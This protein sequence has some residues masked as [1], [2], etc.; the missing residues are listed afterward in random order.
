MKRPVDLFSHSRPRKKQTGS[1]PRP[2]GLSVSELLDSSDAVALE[3][4]VEYHDYQYWVLSSPVISDEDYDLLTRRLEELKPDS[5]VL[6][7]VGGGGLAV[8]SFR[9]KVDHSSPMLSLDKCYDER[10]FAGWLKTT[11][12]R[13]IKNAVVE[14][15]HGELARRYGAYG[16]VASEDELPFLASSLGVA[17]SPKIDGVAASVKYDERGCLILAATRG[18]GTS[19]EDFTVNARL[20][21][22]IPWEVAAS[23]V[24]VRGEVYMRRS[25]FRAKYQDAFP[26]P[27]NLTAGTLKQKESARA[28]L[29]DL[30]FFAYDLL[31]LEFNTEEEKAK[32]LVELGFTPVESQVV[33]AGDVPGLYEQALLSREE[34]DFDADG[35]VIRL[36]D[37]KLQEM[38]G[39]TA[40]HPRFAIAF[41]FQ[42]DTGITELEEV[43]WSVARSG[44][45]TPV[46][47]VAPVLLSGARV[48]RS[49][50]HNISEFSKLG[51]AI[52]D[53]VRLKRRGDVIPKVEA[54]LGGGGRRVEIPTACPSCGNQTLLAAPQLFVSGFRLTRFAD[55]EQLLALAGYQSALARKVGILSPAET[56]N[57]VARRTGDLRYKS[58]LTWQRSDRDKRKEATRIISQLPSVRHK[59]P[60]VIILVVVDPAVEACRRVLSM[61][62]DM[63]AEH[64]IDIRIVPATRSRHEDGPENRD[65]WEAGCRGEYLQWLFGCNSKVE[66]FGASGYA[67]ENGLFNEENRVLWER[68]AHVLSEDSLVC[69]QPQSC[70]DVVVGGLEHFIQTLGVDGFGRKIIVNLHDSGLLRHREDFFTLKAEDLVDLER[71]GETLA[72]KLLANV[73]GARNPSLSLFLQSLGIDEVARNVS[74]ILEREY[75]TIER[76]LE[77]TERELME[78]ESIA[79][80]IAHQVVHGLRRNREI[81]GRLLEHVELLPP[82]VAA[83]EEQGAF[84]GASFVFTGKMRTMPRKAA[85]E[86]VAQLGGEVPDGVRTD[87]TW[88]V[89]GDEGSPLF[90]EGTRGGKLKKADRYNEKGAAIRIISETVF[91]DMLSRERGED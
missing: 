63:L 83:G 76:V 49:T 15:R 69:S 56:H 1:A 86:A 30:D 78:H 48:S 82:A 11:V 67:V 41:K 27:R 91:L 73:A 68:L 51:L 64:R 44:T 37:V 39:V 84:A 58:A 25:V 5:A 79:F 35:L 26:N 47:L 50:L 88:L 22:G 61:A 72:S 23:L 28:Q 45:I 24:E 14:G 10:K 70:R 42:G 85:Q 66:S 75:G 55:P 60:Q 13:A 18:D 8:H 62:C 32:R 16:E 77:V 74:T 40:H 54:N 9:Q 21:S 33:E 36:S 7:R 17:V 87:L 71:M 20:V 6:N 31:G 29:L 4:A 52:G 12:G 90:G 34:W 46:A 81:I 43:Q 59:N 3:R 89:V 57:S 80:G 38:L 19:G 65:G 53:R 2:E